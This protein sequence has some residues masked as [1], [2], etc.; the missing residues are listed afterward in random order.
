MMSIPVIAALIMVAMH[1][2]LGMHVVRR[3]VI[4]VDIAL[5]QIAA[6]GVAVSMLFGAEV[7]TGAAFW[8][9]LGSTLVGAI[10][11]SFTRSKVEKVPQEAYIGI[12]YVIFSAGMILVLSQVA[13]GGEEVHNLLVGSILWVSWGTVL[14]T[15][16][17]YG[18]LAVILL[19]WHR[20]FQSIS[21]DPEVAQA[22]GRSLQ[23]W[24]FLF[25]M[26]LGTVVTISVQIAGVLLVFTML[27]VPAVMAMR[28]LDAARTQIL[29]VLLVGTVA[30][31][32]GSSVSY[33]YDLPTGATIVCAFGC[34]LVLQ[35]FVEGCRSVLRH[36]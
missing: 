33:V 9:G 16:L 28:I 13:H 10:L 7:G 32:C 18:V 19:W 27:V 22:K 21:E 8:V 5:A 25:Y 23:L 31:V 35:I 24:D 36:S 2:Y 15:A 3:S 30:V 14:K 11:L 34:L 6:F 29:Y 17:V 1:G 12:V 20:P 26:V 4:F